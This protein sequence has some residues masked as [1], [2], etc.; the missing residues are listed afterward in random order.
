MPLD[1]LA[2]KSFYK[3]N[4]QRLIKILNIN[5]GIN[6]NLLIIRLLLSSLHTSNNRRKNE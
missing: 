6:F 4:E 5:N 2:K 1:T 3:L